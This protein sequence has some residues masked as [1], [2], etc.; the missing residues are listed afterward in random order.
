MRL[1]T[2]TI[3]FQRIRTKAATT[4]RSEGKNISAYSRDWVWPSERATT[5][6]TREAFHTNREANPSFSLK[7]GTLTIRG[8]DVEGGA[9]QH[10]DGKAEH[11]HRGVHGAQPAEDEPGD[12]AQQV[13]G[14]QLDPGR[15]P[16]KGADH[17]PDA[18][19]DHVTEGRGVASRLHLCRFRTLHA[20]CLFSSSGY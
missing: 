14:D 4:P 7:S 6:A 11:D 19:T 16:G 13:R 12:V 2:V 9:E 3:R 10:G 8:H 18:R 5:P 20:S 15:D 17:H 1:M